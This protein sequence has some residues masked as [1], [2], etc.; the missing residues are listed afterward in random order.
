MRRTGA[1]GHVSACTGTGWRGRTVTAGAEKEEAWGLTVIR[2]DGGSGG[3]GGRRGRRR[4]GSRPV[5]RR[6]QAGE[7]ALRRGPGV[8]GRRGA[9]WSP[10]R[11]RSKSGE[12]GEIFCGGGE[13]SVGGGVRG[14]GGLREWVGWPA[15][16]GGLAQLGHSPGGFLLSF[17]L[18]VFSFVFFFFLFIFFSVLNHFKLSRH[19]IKMCLSHHIYLCKIWHLPNIFV[20][21]FEKLLLLTLI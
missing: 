4:R 3:R 17:C 18:F 7:D 5:G 1:R 20:V 6:R 21:N 13:G 14:P 11:S 8:G 2:R 15:G 19:F 10:P 16:P 12:R 9:R